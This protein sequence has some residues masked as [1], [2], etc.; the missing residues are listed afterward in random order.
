MPVPPRHA[1]HLS[2]AFSETTVCVTGGA[3]FIGSHLVDALLDLGAHTTVIDDL[4]TADLAHL[5][6]RITENPERL[7]FVHGSILDDEALRAAVAEARLVV[8][9][10]ALSSV[11]RSLDDPE[12]SFA[13][14]ATG[15][16]RVL[17]AAQSAGARRVVLAASSSAYGDTDELPKHE[18]MPPRPRSPYAAGKLAGEH[19]AAAAAATS[20]LDTAALRFFNVFGPRQTV[21]SPYAAVIPRFAARLL[22]GKAPIIHGDGAQTRD[23]THVD[24]AVL[25]LLLAAAA[26]ERLDGAVLN[27]GC[28]AR[29]TVA[30]L[31]RLMAEAINPEAPA[32]EHVDPRPGDVHDS[33]ADLTAVRDTLGYEP[34][35]EFEPGVRAVARWYAEA[36]S[37]T[38][39]GP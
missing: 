23:F 24:N 5:A 12:R 14:N 6:P 35:T 27:V 19:L 18:R 16:L 29:H 25:A 20:D 4:S 8:H 15:T 3:G 11:P 31:A 17:R 21:D 34:V 22:E 30:D 26:T 10:A 1:D 9:L 38:N 36:A 33:L 28:G 13:V 37:A 2:V 7:R 39:A 32:P